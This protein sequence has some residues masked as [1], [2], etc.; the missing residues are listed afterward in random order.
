MEKIL[1]S[2]RRFLEAPPNARIRGSSKKDWHTGKHY[3]NGGFLYGASVTTQ[4]NL[5][6]VLRYSYIGGVS[7]KMTY[8]N[9]YQLDDQLGLGLGGL[10]S[11]GWELFPFS[12][13]LDYYANVGQW[14]DDQ[15]VIPPGALLYLV[16][17]RK[18]HASGVEVGHPVPFERTDALLGVR[19]KAGSFAYGSF[20]RTKLTKLPH[21]GFRLRSFD[22]VGKNAIQKLANLASLAKL[23][24]TKVTKERVENQRRLKQSQRAIR[25]GVRGALLGVKTKTKK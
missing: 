22:E 18:Y 23:D 19:T 25:R 17:T 14:L 4:W 20:K 1:E 9:D 12:W 11:V 8:D 15:F 13:V 24:A 21:I 2:I 10:P 3:P 7:F 16:E 5:H 6:H